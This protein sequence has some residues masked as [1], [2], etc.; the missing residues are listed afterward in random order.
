MEGLEQFIAAPGL[1]SC[2]PPRLPA[3][4]RPIHRLLHRI[5]VL[6]AFVRIFPLEGKLG[7]DMHRMAVRLLDVDDSDPAIRGLI[8]GTLDMARGLGLADTLRNDS[9]RRGHV[10]AVWSA[11]L[12]SALGRA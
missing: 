3:A 5:W 12:A 9:H 1:S 11:Q 2:R 8:Q 7:R 4:G 10:V 6:T